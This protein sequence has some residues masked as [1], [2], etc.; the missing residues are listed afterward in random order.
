MRPAYHIGRE[1]VRVVLLIR[2][3]SVSAGRLLSLLSN[4]LIVTDRPAVCRTISIGAVSLVMWLDGILLVF[5][6][7]MKG[8]APLM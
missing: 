8:I 5:S 4:S 6:L 1:H 7:I 2:P 3:S